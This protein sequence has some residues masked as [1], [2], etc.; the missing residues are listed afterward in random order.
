[1]EAADPLAEKLPMSAPDSSESA[2]LAGVHTVGYGAA[3]AKSDETRKGSCGW[4]YLDA[5]IGEF[6]AGYVAIIVAVYGLA[7]GADAQLTG[8]ATSYLYSDTLKVTPSRLNELSGLAQI[9]WNTKP[10][11]GLMSDTLP[12]LGYHRYP[13]IAISALAGIASCLGLYLQT[14]MGTVTAFS[15]TW[16]LLLG[17]MSRTV[18]KF[19]TP[20]SPYDF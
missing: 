11:F 1:M 15:A 16:F 13:Y 9:P 3:S 17:A 6:G 8:F 12:I 5:L 4:S 7:Q 10:L 20:N 19:G 14:S 18:L 2:L